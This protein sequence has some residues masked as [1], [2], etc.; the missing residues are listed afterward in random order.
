MMDIDV[1]TIFENWMQKGYEL[2]V[3][4]N[5]DF[6]LYKY[7]DAYELAESAQDSAKTRA[8]E[9]I[10]RIRTKLANKEDGFTK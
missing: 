7:V 6:A 3:Q 4:G 5:Y 8:K 1:R 10:N 9:A 2:E